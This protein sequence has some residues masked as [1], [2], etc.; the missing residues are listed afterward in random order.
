MEDNVVI[1]RCGQLTKDEKSELAQGSSGISGEE[2]GSADVA[3]CVQIPLC[4]S[5]AL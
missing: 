4:L 3:F 5:A 1:D 2:F